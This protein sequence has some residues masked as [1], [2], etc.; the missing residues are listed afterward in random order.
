[1]RLPPHAVGPVVSRRRY[2]VDN[3][4]CHSVRAAAPTNPSNALP[5]L[6]NRSEWRVMRSMV[7]VKVPLGIC[8]SQDESAGATAVRSPPQRRHRAPTRSWPRRSGSTRSRSFRC[9]PANALRARR[10]ARPSG[11]PYWSARLREALVPG[12]TPGH[13][14]PPRIPEPRLCRRARSQRGP[15][16]RTSHRFGE[17]RGSRSRRRPRTSC[18]YRPIPC[19]CTRVGTAALPA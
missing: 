10:R 18:G 8:C 15:R 6:Q 4:V 13:R 19:A 14:R 5:R 2:A 3:T 17:P 11:R 1:M 12:R 16:A 7:L 9:R